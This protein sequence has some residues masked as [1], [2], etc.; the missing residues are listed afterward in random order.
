MDVAFPEINF[1][2]AIML[3][4]A[5]ETVMDA[6]AP[7]VT[8]GWTPGAQLSVGEP[9]AIALSPEWAAS[10]ADLAGFIAAEAA[11]HRYW[12]V[13]LACTLVP[14]PDCRIERISLTCYLGLEK[15]SP[16]QPP[17]AMSMTP[18][19]V[20]DVRS[21]KN[22]W[23]VKL[24][25]GLKLLTPEVGY[26]H[27]TE[28]EKGASAVVAYNLLGSQPFW[29]MQ[30]NDQLPLEG[31]FRFALVARAER[32][33]QANLRLAITGSARARRLGLFPFRSDLPLGLGERRRLP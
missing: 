17:I 18:E 23:S 32:T 15:G 9:V 10:S 6:A 28:R 33:A 24:G 16:G 27:V 5:E 21:L 29:A 12:L 14:A 30:E 4:A 25:A 13:H 2:P 26:D 11:T 31:S 8:R 3:P 20:M 19:R 1:A 7:A 22:E